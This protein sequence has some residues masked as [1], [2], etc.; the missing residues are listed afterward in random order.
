[1]MGT[2]PGSK[3]IAVK[4]KVKCLMGK[5]SGDALV[6]FYQFDINYIHLGEG[7]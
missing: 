2:I 1:M 4:E 6:S 3:D 7:A 5:Y